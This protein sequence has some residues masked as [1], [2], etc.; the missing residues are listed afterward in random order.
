MWW[1]WWFGP[2]EA[3]A[4]VEV[5]SSGSGVA[6]RDSKE[7]GG[8]ILRFTKEEW[9]AFLTGAKAGDFDHLC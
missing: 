2:C 1:W 3:G 6:I 9:E 4:C 5:A 8:P 7:K